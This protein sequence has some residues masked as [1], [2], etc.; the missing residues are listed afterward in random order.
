MTLK[1]R[2][3]FLMAVCGAFLLAPRANALEDNRLVLDREDTQ[4]HMG[5]GFTGTY[6]GAEIFKLRG[7]PAWRATAYGSLMMLTAGL[8]KE[9]GVDAFPSG[10]DLKADLLG[11]GTGAGLQMAVAWKWG[12]KGQDVPVLIPAEGRSTPAAEGGSADPRAEAAE[13]ALKDA[14]RWVVAKHSNGIPAGRLRIYDGRIISRYKEFIESHEI[15]SET[16][17]DG[18]QVVK[19]G[20]KVY[21]DRIREAILAH[22]LQSAGEHLELQ[23]LISRLSG[24]S[25]GLDGGPNG[26]AVENRAYSASLMG[27]AMRY[28]WTHKTFTE[29]SILMLTKDVQVGTFR[30][31]AG[32]ATPL[33]LTRYS[34]ITLSIG[35]RWLDRGGFRLTS[36][37]G[38]SW[39]MI[40]GETISANAAFPTGEFVE[41]WALA[42]DIQWLPTRWAGLGL[43]T[44]YRNK[45][46]YDIITGKTARKWLFAG[47]LLLGF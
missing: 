11:T 29:G 8:V 30:S 12:R 4:L 3:S 37:L 47:E 10:N 19:V 27:C 1:L 2:P 6:L 44:E 25:D 14:V 45:T 35:R 36:S 17:E 21:A 39:T 26:T 38:R 28:Y 43:R 7:Y 31:A 40:R 33:N 9:F 5:I 13:R 42:S 23:V 20:A 46:R 32:E 24:G 41:S 34:P 15:M 16:W 18:R 22:G